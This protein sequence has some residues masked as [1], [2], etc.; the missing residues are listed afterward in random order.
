MPLPK[1]ISDTLF[2]SNSRDIAQDNRERSPEGVL[3]EN[4]NIAIVQ[5]AQFI[6]HDLVKT[7]VQ[8]MS[9]TI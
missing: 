5:W 7:V 6:E 8:T 9:I 4:R 2:A 1:H 3:D